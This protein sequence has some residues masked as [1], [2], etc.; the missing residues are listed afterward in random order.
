VRV[1][2]NDL[3]AQLG[4]APVSVTDAALQR[5]SN[6]LWF[7]DLSEL[8][9]LL[10]RTLALVRRDTI[11]VA[12][13]RFDVGQRRPAS[14]QSQEPLREPAATSALG[15]GA[16]ELVIN[17]LAHELRNPMVSIKTFAQHLR[18]MG[19]RGADEEQVAKLAGEA[20]DQMDQVVENLLQF[21]RFDAPS[22]ERVSLAA[23]LGPAVANLAQSLK[24]RARRV[25]YRPPAEHAVFVD[26]AQVTYGLTNLFRALARGLGD[27]GRMVVSTTTPG[28]IVVE[29]PGGYDFSEAHLAA[30]LPAL[31]PTQTPL[32][33]PAALATQIIERNGGT[34]AFAAEN[35][36]PRVSVQ[37][38]VADD[39]EVP[40]AHHVQ[41]P[42]SHR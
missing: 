33:L 22:R 25:D 37:L 35:Q 21:T 15:S 27:T 23:V 8:Q 42:R 6:H 36:P 5:L 41:T 28:Q 12:D 11:D 14:A 17:E 19:F 18:R 31:H 10:A 3:A 9:G 7:G 30:L 38:P 34:V 4:L 20:V 26:R 29:L 32:P 13:L 24:P 1:I 39:E 16:L 40:L 2:T